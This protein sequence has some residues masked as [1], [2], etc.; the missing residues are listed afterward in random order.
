M[1][2]AY[3]SP[4]VA[5]LDAVSVPLGAP[6]LLPPEITRE[7]HTWLRSTQTRDSLEDAPTPAPRST[8]DVGAKI[9]EL[10][11]QREFGPALVDHG[12]A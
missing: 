12:V 3:L 7:V 4:V 8:L 10:L 11:H 9:N 2:V 6:L 1:D 5:T